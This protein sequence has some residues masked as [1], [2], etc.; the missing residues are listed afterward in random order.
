M[1]PLATGVTPGLTLTGWKQEFQK[2]LDLAKRDGNFMVQV[3]AGGSLGEG[4][5]HEEVW[6]NERKLRIEKVKRP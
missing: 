5:K 6:A 3:T 1:G 4:Q 2:H